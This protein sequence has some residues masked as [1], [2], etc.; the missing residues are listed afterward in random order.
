MQLQLRGCLWYWKGRWH[1]W[2]RE[3]G[4]KTSNLGSVISTGA[5]SSSTFYIYMSWKSLEILFEESLEPQR[6]REQWLISGRGPL[7]K[8]GRLQPD[9]HR[10]Q[11]LW[12]S[13]ALGGSTPDPSRTLFFGGAHPTSSSRNALGEAGRQPVSAW[14]SSGSSVPVAI[15]QQPTS[16]SPPRLEPPKC[17]EEE[18]LIVRGITPLVQGD[19]VDKKS[20]SISCS[21]TII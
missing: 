1:G 6:K 11:L 9:E 3:T 2:R 18:P 21:S 8:P 13:S 4:A 20:N 5:Q 19:Q 7:A 16:L 12:F 15:V 14:C 17:S 10:P